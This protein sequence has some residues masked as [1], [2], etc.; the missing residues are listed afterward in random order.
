MKLRQGTIYDNSDYGQK[1]SLNRL[2]WT[3]QQSRIVKIKNNLQVDVVACRWTNLILH[4][5]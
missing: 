5:V 4:G 3:V 2:Q 1:Q